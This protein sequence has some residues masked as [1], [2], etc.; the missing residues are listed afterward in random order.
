MSNQPPSKPYEAFPEDIP[1]TIERAGIGTATDIKTQ[2]LPLCVVLRMLMNKS[3]HFIWS[4][5][6]DAHDFVKVDVKL[7][8]ELE[9]LDPDETLLHVQWEDFEGKPILFHDKWSDRVIPNVACVWHIHAWRTS[10][11][12]WLWQQHASEAQRQARFQEVE[13]YNTF[14]S[15]IE[16]QDGISTKQAEEMARFIIKGK[17]K[18]MARVYGWDLE[19]RK[20]I[21]RV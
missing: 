15:L 19:A 14:V 1:V 7:A 6:Y 4:A 13:A 8:K 17:Y 10:V 18:P 11:A 20:E 21:E 5:V 2:G 3:G 9:R 16:K 12:R